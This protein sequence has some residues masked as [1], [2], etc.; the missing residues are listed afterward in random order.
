MNSK[1]NCNWFLTL[2]NPTHY[3]LN[4]VFDIIND[5]KGESY[6]EF[7]CGFEGDWDSTNPS[8]TMHLQ[9]CFVTKKPVGFFAIKK[10]FP[11]AHI[12]KVRDLTKSLEYVK[13][14]GLY[15]SL[16]SKKNNP[17]RKW[18]RDPKKREASI[19]SLYNLSPSSASSHLT[20]YKIF[21]IKKL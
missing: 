4:N 5:G 20:N 21:A 9:I 19:T 2:N 18:E 10:L 8:H 17:V 13:K 12:E 11:R 3:E 16:T 7:V 1:F 15:F 6:N 14:E